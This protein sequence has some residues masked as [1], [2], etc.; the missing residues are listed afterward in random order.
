MFSWRTILFSWRTSNIFLRKICIS[1]DFFVTL[2]HKC[3]EY[4]KTYLHLCSADGA[5]RLSGKEPVNNCYAIGC[6]QHLHLSV[7]QDALREGAGTLPG[8]HRHCRD[9][10]YDDRR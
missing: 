9:E 7:Y 5:G 4:E 6:R 10:G 2:P 8:T 1:L 3:N